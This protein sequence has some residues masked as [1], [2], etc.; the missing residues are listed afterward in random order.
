MTNQMYSQHTCWNRLIVN[1]SVTLGG[2]FLKDL[3]DVLGRLATK[4]V[5]MHYYD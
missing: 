5:L 4:R 1:A 2:H 3:P